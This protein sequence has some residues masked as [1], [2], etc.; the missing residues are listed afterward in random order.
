MPALDIQNPGVAAVA[1]AGALLADLLQDAE[2]AKPTSALEPV[3]NPSDLGS[4]EGR[5]SA[6]LVSLAA[7]D[8]DNN[9]EAAK[10]LHFA[11]LETAARDLFGR[12]IATTSIDSPEF[13]KMW[14]LLDI[15]SILSDMGQCDPALLFWLVEELLDSQTIAGCRKIFDY[16]ESRRER[17]TS[18]HF[19]QKNLVILRSCNELLRRLSRAEDTAFCGRVF[20]FLFQSFPLGDRSSVNLRGEYHVENVTNFEPPRA[21][22][23]DSKM[24]ID[25]QI[26]PKDST[27]TK[28]GNKAVPKKTSKAFDPDSLYASFWSLQE[29]FSQPLKLLVPTH[30]AHFKNNLGATLKAFQAIHNGEGAQSSKS[31]ENMRRDLKRKREE[32]EAGD[33]LATF[34]PKYLTSKDLFE[35]EISDLSFRRHVLVQALIIIDFILSLTSGAKEKLAGF[36]ASNK[37]VMYN[38]Q[39]DEENTKW[40]N[41][42]K[43]TISD[44]LKRGP[45]G[46]Y[47][48]RMVETVLARDKNWVF[49][50]M[51]SCPPIQRKPVST[52]TFK[53]SK[54]NAQRMA[55][56]KRLR[57]N[58]LGAVSMD[59]IRDDPRKLSMDNLQEAERY[60]LPELDGFKRTIANDEFEIEMPTNEQT[61]AAAVAGKASKSWRALRIGGRSKL[62]AFDRIDDSK[63]IDSV[64]EELVEING[65]PDEDAADEEDMPQNCEP[66]IVSGLKG[67]SRTGLVEQLKQRHKGVFATVVR[68][69]VREPRDDEVRG[70]SFHFVTDREFGQL[71]DGDRL[72]EHGTRDGVE[73]GTST[74]AIDAVAQSGK[75]P[76]IELDL[77]A[78]KFAREMNFAARYVLVDPPTASVPQGAGSE[79]AGDVQT[80]VT[81]PRDETGNAAKDAA[82]LFDKIVAESDL[83]RAAED[84]GAYVFAEQGSQSQQGEKS[85]APVEAEVGLEDGDTSMADAPPEETAK[86]AD[87]D[88][89][90]DRTEDRCIEVRT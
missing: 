64:F 44:Y 71:R 27:D 33:G 84:L 56:S 69:A 12:L 77:E 51:A 48:N 8:T 24:V 57:P 81:E 31:M 15:L 18:K 43:T 17:I 28:A 88:A 20:I 49:W 30:M 29:C 83:E 46:P 67:T 63:N 39:L 47:F 54:G 60:A 50:K 4:L 41:E 70:Q 37:S 53:E 78:A 11:I 42:M 3:L 76:V 40:A 86:E 13:V 6:S 19:K 25:D 10:T 59:F 87:D 74:N 45:D 32:D 1:G 5:I 65:A 79:S 14:N 21:S 52:E 72:V 55:T 9:L 2:L 38:D 23:E 26:M 16:L 75:V 7:S 85:N 61:K 62:A 68:H 22:E 73:Y 89:R 80:T 35:L 90:S 36:N 82:A 34:N 66:V 58:P